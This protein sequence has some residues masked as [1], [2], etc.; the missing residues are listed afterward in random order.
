MNDDKTLMNGEENEDLEAQL[1]A[2]GLFDDDSVDD[3]FMDTN[4]FNDFIPDTVSE[5]TQAEPGVDA[6]LEALL[7]LG[8]TQTD[9]TQ[10]SSVDD[11]LEALLGLGAT[12]SDATRLSSVDD[13]L[14]ALLGLGEAAQ[15]DATRLSSVD[16]D[17]EALLGLGDADSSTQLA[18][19]DAELDS[20]FGAAFDDAQEFDLEAALG[21][22]E[23]ETT[24]SIPVV[25]DEMDLDR[26]LEMLLMADQKATESFE[27]K[28]VS[29]ASPS[30]SI[31]DPE[32]DG[33]GVVSY[34]KGAVAFKEEKKKTKL[35]ENVTWGKLI[36][37]AVI[38]LSTIA[39]SAILAI[40]VGTA[41]RAEQDAVLAL[42]HFVPISVPVNTANNANNIFVNQ[43][44][45]FRGQTFTLTRITPGIS[46]TLFFFAE[47]WNPD[48]FHVLLY[49]QARFLYGRI[50]FGMSPEGGTILKFER[51]QHNTLFLTL[52][53]QCKTTHESVLFEY[54][55]L[56]P[57]ALAA[58]VYVSAPLA[59]TPDQNPDHAGVVI[60][61]ARFDNATSQLHF[62]F[63]T[64]FEGAGLR[65]ISRDFLP[66]IT[67][68]DTFGVL[69]PYT[70][71]PAVHDFD[72]FGVIIGTT[73]FSPVAS[74]DG[75]AHVT[76]SD[77]VYRYVNPEVD[78][79]PR[80]LF[81]RD[82]FDP[83]SIS[84]GPYTLNLE[85][86]AQQHNLVVLVVHALDENN[87][88]VQVNP[89][90]SLQI[91]ID[92][93]RRFTI[94][95]T[96]NMARFGTDILFDLMPY[97]SEIR[98]IPI[99][100]YS[101]IINHVDL[102]LPGITVTLELSTIF[103]M[104]SFRRD[105]AEAAVIQAIAGLLAY[106]SNEITRAGIVG[107]SDELRASDELFDLFTAA[108]LIERPMYGV[109]LV[110]GDLLTN[111]DYVAIVEVQW[112]QGQ[113][114][115]IEVFHEVLEVVARSRDGIWSL[116]RIEP[117]A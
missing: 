60:R 93:F 50:S 84:L 57:P 100:R 44:A 40:Y 23:P 74:L 99:S 38:G 14:E 9:A 113:G 67:M 49:N 66:Q 54:R 35:F 108:R 115:H 90:I 55:F 87:R 83:H 86:M 2:L 32:V 101:L 75:V 34:V 69:T 92:A 39:F 18:D 30:K 15:A 97:I 28:D 58:A 25:T 16:D 82:Q 6:E 11:E 17:L 3:S 37:T 65:V 77:V 85:A 112:T 109:S 51:L 22:K 96:V 95:G 64:D 81:D 24:T 59:I 5:P 117:V 62:S 70:T 102:Y 53:I 42:S 105:A 76:L 46:G 94:P 72:D 91:E 73:Y 21:L 41:V 13:E 114:A 43:V 31:Y 52:R 110:T 36:A 107:L 111:Y 61:H 56:E 63:D 19:V 71:I 104:P 79:M 26:Q 80:D 68:R 88:R 1:A 78:I 116:T 7:G 106:K 33:M 103:G 47:N 27:I 10:L 4:D 45:E 12:Q 20:M 98:D 89:N 48:D 29:L 8:A